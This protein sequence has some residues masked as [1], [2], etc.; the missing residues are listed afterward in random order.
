LPLRQ[1]GAVAAGNA[2]EAYDFVSFGFFAIQLG[3]TFF[4]ANSEQNSLLLTLATFGA[5]FFMRPVGGLIIGRL[6]DVW[7]RKPAMLLS[8]GLM[9]ASVVGMVLTP[10]YAQI[11]IA[12]PLLIVLFRL[13]QGFAMGG[14]IGPS[15]AFLLE[16][17]PASRRGF[18]VSLQYAT[19][20]L[21]VL[22]AGLVGLTLANFMTSDALAQWGWR[23]AFLVGTT[24]V[25]FGLWVRRRLPESLHPKSRGALQRPSLARLRLGLLFV[26]LLASNNVATYTLNYLTTFGGHTLGLPPRITF[27]TTVAIGLVGAVLY[28]VGGWLSDQRGRK[29][30]MIIGI[31]LLFLSALPCFLA[32]TIWR[33]PLALIGGSAVMTGLLSL[34][35]GPYLAAVSE[36]LPPA[37]R[38]AGLGLTYALPVSLF[39]GTAQFVVTWLIGV[40]GSSLVPAWYMMAFLAG[41]LVCIG[42]I[43]ETAPKIIAPSGQT[44]TSSPQVQELSS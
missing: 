30:V 18:Y 44:E 4:P 41:G 5:G 26:V 31:G 43:D 38:S 39:G 36:H 33:T 42:S 40:T 29:P 2:L 17:A 14:E 23:I 37:M 11:G 19:Q 20:N 12:A 10:S 24:V 15:T 3:K 8:F 21:G 9:G 6:G 32:M 13:I 16:A 1:I 35:S 27:G 25:P 7:G 22:T 28:P 34:G